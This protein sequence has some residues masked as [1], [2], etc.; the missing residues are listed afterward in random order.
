MCRYVLSAAIVGSVAAW[1]CSD[2][3]T[4]TETTPAAVAMPPLGSAWLV[5][6]AKATWKLPEKAGA[7]VTEQTAVPFLIGVHAV[8]GRDMD[9][10]LAVAVDNQ[11]DMCSRTIVVKGFKLT[12]E[13][14]ISFGPQ[15]L[16]IAN[17]ARTE[18][19]ELTAKLSADNKVLSD[20]DVKG[21]IDMESMPQGLLPLPAET[22]ACALAETLQ[23]P[24]SACADGKDHCLVAHV[25]HD[26][27]EL[28]Q[29]VKLEVIT[30]VDCHPKCAASK[31]NPDCK[32]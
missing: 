4:D 29:D 18:D 26:K 27:L 5:D 21:K 20:F 9:M 16:K 15:L 14:V 8:K 1:G 24:C 7:L 30:E 28:M 3:A 10:L 13:R 25:V 6:T 11:Q 12:D 32:L 31:D 19:F 23:M 17:G 2:S 22:T